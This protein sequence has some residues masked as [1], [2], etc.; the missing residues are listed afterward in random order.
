MIK[1]GELSQR[2]HWSCTINAGIGKA[3]IHPN[4]HAPHVVI[5]AFQFLDFEF[6]RPN[7]L[8]NLT[9]HQLL[10]F[11]LKFAHNFC[12]YS[13]FPSFLFYTNLVFT[14]TF[15][16]RRFQGTSLPVHSSGE[17]FQ[18]LLDLLSNSLL[19]CAS[20]IPLGFRLVSLI[21][22]FVHFSKR[23]TGDLTFQASYLST[24]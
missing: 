2:S 10:I 6:S 4:P 7:C 16:F 17:S 8:T 5:L 22:S 13:S 15:L 9:F 19:R 11:S 3:Q 12:L 23:I 20:W 14:P 1:L 21:F 24:L 18:F